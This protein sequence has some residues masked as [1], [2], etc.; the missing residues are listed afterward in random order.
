MSDIIP[1]NKDFGEIVSPLSFCHFFGVRRFEVYV[2]L[3]VIL[4]NHHR[5][6]FV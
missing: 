2:V 1:D 5:K 3:V 6:T 4:P